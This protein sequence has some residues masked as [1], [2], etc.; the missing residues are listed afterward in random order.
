M[1]MT[2]FLSASLSVIATL[3]RTAWIAHSALRPRFCA[4]LS[5]NDAVKFSIFSPITPLTSW[6]PPA[7]GW[8]APM[9]VPGAIAATWAASVIN[10]PAEP[11]PA[12]LGPTQTMTGT[13]AP[14]ISLTIVRV[15]VSSPPGVS[16]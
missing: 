2:F 3:L 15:E 11:A 10:T 16:S 7:T 14:S 12:P 6:P 4:M 9:L 13:C 5:L 1:S 8:A